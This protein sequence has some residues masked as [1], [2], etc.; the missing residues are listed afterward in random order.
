[1]SLWTRDGRCLEKQT[2]PN[3]RSSKN[4]LPILDTAAIAHW[5]VGALRAFSSHPVEAI[6]P[7]AHGAA[8]AGIINGRLAFA[9]PDYE[10]DYAAELRESYVAHRDSFAQTGSPLLPAGLNLGSQLH[11]LEALD[12][13]GFRATTLMPYAQYWAW[14][15]SGVAVSEV[16]SLGCHTDMWSPASNMFSDMA[17]RRGWARQFAPLV[18]AG[19]VVGTLLPALAAQTGL[20]TDVRIHAGLH[21]SNAALLA[22]RSFAEMQGQEATL[23]STGTW[24]IAMRSSAAEVDLTA[25]P[26]DRDCL[27]SVDAFGQPVPTARFMGGRE[28]ELL[29]QRIDKPGLAGLDAV[30]RSGAMILPSQVEGCGPFP[31]HKPHWINRLQ[32]P[33]EQAATIA[34]Y[35]A[36]MADVLLA[37]SGATDRVLIEGRFAGAEL[38]TRALAALRPEMTVYAASAEADVAFGALRLIWPDIAPGSKLARVNPL[39]QDLAAYRALWSVVVATH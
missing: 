4:D 38:F 39:D 5:L 21:D 34:L 24:F 37:L 9:S 25:L 11:A 28:V 35:A 26:E 7:V 17:Q 29:G 31:D 20:S 8:V 16:T 15:L 13:D 18:H 1:V 23:L 14:F 3:A 6:I 33:D 12:H 22:A 19:T 10:G 27:I 36:L 32:D 2:R 30:L